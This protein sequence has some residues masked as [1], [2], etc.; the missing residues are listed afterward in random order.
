MIF[1]PI[2]AF[3]L[4]IIKLTNDL[5][6]VVEFVA[7]GKKLSCITARNP[8]VWLFPLPQ[9]LQHYWYF[10]S[11][12]RHS[13]STIPNF[14]QVQKLNVFTNLANVLKLCVHACLCIVM[15]ACVCVCVLS[16]S[17]TNFSAVLAQIF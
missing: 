7:I 16:H 6:E 2:F 13:R 17:L 9:C 15:H 1:R 5:F 3:Y 11:F 14:F 8:G 10:S 12:L 4:T